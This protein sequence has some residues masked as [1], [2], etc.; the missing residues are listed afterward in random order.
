MPASQLYLDPS[1]WA[2]FSGDRRYRYELTRIWDDGIPPVLF[3]GM[4]PSTA[5]ETE[6]DPTIRRCIRFARDWGYGGLLM[7][8]LY[9]LRATD[10]QELTRATEPPEVFSPIAEHEPG[11]SGR[12]DYVNRND[13]SLKSMRKRA[14][15]AIAAWG[16][17][18]EPPIFDRGPWVLKLL[19][20]MHALGFTKSGRPRHPLYVRAD[21]CPVPCSRGS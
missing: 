13:R 16:S 20:P 1:A 7:G 4:N 21:T 9:A 6:D 8:N 2:L 10:P 3:V 15:L 17:I 19:A 12:W 5:D 14:G 11:R 18:A